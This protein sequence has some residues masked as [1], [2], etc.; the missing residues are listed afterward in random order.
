MVQAASKQLGTN[1]PDH[2]TPNWIIIITLFYLRF[3]LDDNNDKG[4]DYIKFF[5]GNYRTA[6]YRPQLVITYYVP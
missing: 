5:S 6:S 2:K 1:N 3:K 4:A